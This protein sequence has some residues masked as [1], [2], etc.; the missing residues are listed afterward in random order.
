MITEREFIMSDEEVLKQAKKLGETIGNSEVWI[1]FKKA[2]E[3]FKGDEGVQKLLT[4]LREKEKKQA[5]KIE[6]GQPIEVYEKKEIQK[7]EEQLSQNK[8]FMEFLNYEK[9]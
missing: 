1:D 9:R 8:N 3:V 4:E 7:L 6:K 2:R 5:E